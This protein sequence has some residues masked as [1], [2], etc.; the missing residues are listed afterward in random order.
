MFDAADVILVSCSCLAGRWRRK[1][2]AA[3][4]NS[5]D[6]QYRTRM[7]AKPFAGFVLWDVVIN[8]DDRTGK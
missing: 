1:W 8:V 4:S 5:R 7:E 3:S 2:K 6:C